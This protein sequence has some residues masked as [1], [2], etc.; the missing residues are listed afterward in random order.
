MR[1]D[2]PPSPDALIHAVLDGEASAEQRAELDRRMDADPALRAKFDEMQ[3]V[4]T[5]LEAVP[6]VDPPAGLVQSILARATLRAVP[7]ELSHQPFAGAN[8]IAAYPGD[9]KAIRARRSTR[10]NWFPVL[11][12]FMREIGMSDSKPGFLGTNKGKLLV[13]A[14]VAAVALVGIST[15]IDF[16]I[17]GTS[18]TGT[19]VPAERHRAP[20]N[21][22][23]DINVGSPGGTTVQTTGTAGSAANNAAGQ[24]EI[25]V[26]N[27]PELRLNNPE[28]RLNNPELRLNN[29]EVLKLNNPE[30]LKLNNPEL[31]LNNPELRLNNP[32]LR[33]NN[34]EL[35]LNNAEVKAEAKAEAKA[36]LRQ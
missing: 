12:N 23:E 15:V 16:P 21:A 32:E 8:V 24:A 11:V 22:A 1:N 5:M 6:A 4:F 7:R 18:T 2:M 25:K 9:T 17:G 36:G 27:N 20:Q 29:P 34:P 19:I 14:G 3:R 33:L 31:R 30:V 28:L 35:R 10:G 26:T 13:T